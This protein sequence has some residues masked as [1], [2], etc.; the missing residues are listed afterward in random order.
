MGKN[1]NPNLKKKKIP[2]L[3]NDPYLSIYLFIC[4]CVN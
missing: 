1:P 3:M 4:V 2:Y